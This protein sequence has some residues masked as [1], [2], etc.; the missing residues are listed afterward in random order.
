MTAPQSPHRQRGNEKTI[1]VLNG[2]F[3]RLR[4]WETDVLGVLWVL[5]T[6]VAVLVPALV[7]GTSLGPFD[8]LSQFGLSLHPGVTV[9]NSTNS[10]LIQQFIPWTTLAWTQVHHG[11]LPL[12]NPYS[13]LGMPLAFNWQSATFSVPTMLSYLVPVRFAFTVQLLVTVVVAGTGVYVLGRVLRLGVLG[14]VFAATVYELS[15]PLIGWLGWPQA[16]VMSWAGWLFATALLVVG[17]RHRVR[18]IAL[19]AFVLACMIYA[20]FPEALVLLGLALAVFLVVLLG[21]RV[22][23]L[24]GSGPILHPV[25]DLA[26]GAVAGAAL[27]APLVLPGLQLVSKSWRSSSGALSADHV[28]LPTHDLVNVVFQGFYGLP[29]AGSQWFGSQIFVYPGT[30]AYVGVTALVLAVTGLALRRKSREVIAFGAVL[31]LMAAVV[32][33]PPVISLMNRLPYVGGVLWVR[34]VMPMVLAV[35]VLSGVGIDV[36]IRSRKE[37]TVLLWLGSGFAVAA[38][39][40]LTLWAFGRESSRRW[41]PSSEPRASSGRRS[42]RRWA[43]WLWELWQCTGATTGRRREEIVPA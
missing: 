21:L 27:A 25:V 32:F 8:F 10:D 43:S 3:R 17:D 36:L 24:G 41:T 7:H 12:W 22:P 4:F 39:V 20:G 5:A 42:K 34:V 29:V 23:Q 40:L 16:S 28:G 37:R 19:F 31:I 13:A 35:A 38:V 9:H 18:D 14:C 15:G 6:A 2:S 26:V 33:V 30:A 1:S 11:Q